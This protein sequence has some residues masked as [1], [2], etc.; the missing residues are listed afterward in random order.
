MTRRALHRIR[1]W[2]TSELGVVHIQQGRLEPVIF[3]SNCQ[4]ASIR[5]S[6][7]NVEWATGPGGHGRDRSP[8]PRSSSNRSRTAYRI[9]VC[10]LRTL[11]P[12][13]LSIRRHL[14]AVKASLVGEVRYPKRFDSAA[15]ENL[16]EAKPKQQCK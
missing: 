6:T 9:L 1:G 16:I 11:R 7:T 14:R 3:L 8:E 10:G 12:A 15:R 4:D 5:H 13:P 2:V